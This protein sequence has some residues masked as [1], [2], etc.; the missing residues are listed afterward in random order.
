MHGHYAQKVLGS[1]A[2]VN[3]MDRRQLKFALIKLDHVDRLIAGKAA[4]RST[5]LGNRGP[6]LV[7][8]LMNSQKKD[9]PFFKSLPRNSPETF[10][11]NQ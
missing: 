6:Y 1:S 5:N 11:F 4:I 9:L 8:D 10:L 3:S 2:L 7:F